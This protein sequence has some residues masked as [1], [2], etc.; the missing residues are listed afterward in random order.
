MKR[1]V[2]T[3]F[4]ATAGVVLLAAIGVCS[5]LFIYTGDLPDFDHLSQ[6]APDAPSVV[7]DSCLAS[8]S[9][10]IPFDRIGEPLRDALA[11]AEPAQALPL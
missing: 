7:S 4:L 3:I 5:W 8:P 2:L 1:I 9:T 10:S 6:F 11:A